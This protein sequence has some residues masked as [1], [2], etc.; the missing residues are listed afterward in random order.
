MLTTGLC[1]SSVD[2]NAPQVLKLIG[3]HYSAQDEPNSASLLCIDAHKRAIIWAGVLYAVT[4][5]VEALAMDV[6]GGTPT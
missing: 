2:Y 6:L 1:S 3:S 4:P 5:G